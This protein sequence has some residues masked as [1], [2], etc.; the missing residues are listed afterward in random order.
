MPPKTK[1]DFEGSIENSLHLKEQEN[2]IALCENECKAILELVDSDVLGVETEHFIDA[3]QDNKSTVGLM[4]GDGIVTNM[5]TGAPAYMSKKFKKG[6]K[7]LAIDGQIVTQNGQ[8]IKML[9]G[10]DLPGTLVTIKVQRGK[11]TI[12]GVLKRAC[13]TDLADKRKMF[14]LFTR[15]KD[16]AVQKNDQETGREVDETIDLWTKMLE[17]DQVHD[18]KIVQNVEAMQTTADKIVRSLREHLAQLHAISMT[19]IAGASGIAQSEAD[20]MMQL[21]QTRIEVNSLTQKITIAQ[22][23]ADDWKMRCEKIEQEHSQC[24][25]LIS[26]YKTQVQEHSRSDVVITA[27]RKQIQ[28]TADALMSDHET[29]QTESTKAKIRAEEKRS[30]FSANKPLTGKP[31]GRMKLGAG[32]PGAGGAYVPDAQEVQDKQHKATSLN[33]VAQLKK[34]LADLKREHQPCKEIIAGLNFRLESYNQ[35]DNQSAT[36]NALKLQLL[37][38]VAELSDRSRRCCV[39]LK[40]MQADPSERFIVREFGEQT[41]GGHIWVSQILKGGAAMKNGQLQIGDIVLAVDSVPMIFLP[42]A[43]NALRG[44]TD[45]PVTITLQRPAAGGVMQEITLTLIRKPKVTDNVSSSLIHA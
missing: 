3:S 42:D 41:Y 27:L 8:V 17:A 9:I 1:E 35:L 26:Q 37:R 2:L 13:T 5:L 21:S 15:L 39:G 40:L 30:A 31:G 43:C 25:I 12:E 16:I 44:P 18:E 29:L 32:A 6:D 45:T 24:S 36:I 4:V 33:I 34:E 11:Q 14:Q 22:Q 38:G 28:E 7:L 20:L 10:N 23:K 19:A